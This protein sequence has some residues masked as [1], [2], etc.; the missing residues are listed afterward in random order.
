MPQNRLNT[1]THNKNSKVPWADP[2]YWSPNVVQIL[3]GASFLA[4][5]ILSVVRRNLNG[6]ALIETTLGVIIFGAHTNQMEEETGDL[7]SA[8]E[9]KENEQLDK[10]LERMWKLDQINYT[11]ELTEEEKTVEKHFM[12]THKRDGDGRFVVEMILKNDIGDI[13]SSREIALRR[14]TYLERRLSKNPE[15]KKFM[16]RKSG[17]IFK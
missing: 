16:W 8:I 15:M 5:I 7:Y 4:K 2:E 17:N 1:S 10:L 12:E 6:T 13:G 3:F 11:E 14:F 9:Y